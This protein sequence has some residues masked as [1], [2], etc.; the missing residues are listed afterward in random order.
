M[1]KSFISTEISQKNLGYY[2][3]GMLP[4]KS[5]SCNN[6]QNLHDIAFDNL[7]KQ[8]EQFNEFFCTIGE[9]LPNKILTYQEYHFQ[10]YLTKQVS[11]SMFLEPANITEIV[12][13]FS[14]LT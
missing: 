2:K 4:S 10:T 7:A 12:N 5:K 3:D 11:K 9:K 8:A 13:K 6:T 14:L 1:E